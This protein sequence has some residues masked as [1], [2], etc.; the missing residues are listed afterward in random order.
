MNFTVQPVDDSNSHDLVRYC[1]EHGSEHDDSY[2]PGPDFIPSPDQ[3]SYLLFADRSVVGAVSLLRSKRFLDA[4]RGR[5]AIFHS[6]LASAAAYK[7]L[8][9]AI[10]PHFAGLDDVY[11]FLPR[12]KYQT[13]AI[14]S[15][16]GFAVERYSF[17]LLNRS[18]QAEDVE[19][20][21]GFAVQELDPTDKPAV[22]A[23]ADSVNENFA[24]LAGHL[25]L[26]PDVVRSWFTD[27]T[28]LKG[29]LLA[30]LENGRI[31]GTIC[32]TREYEDPNLAEISAFG[33]SKGLR[34]RG[35]GRMLLR[36]GVSFALEKGFPS[37]ILSVN[38]ENDSALSLYRSEGFELTETVV[39]YSLTC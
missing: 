14:L 34:G 25:D 9:S 30:L 16:L 26:P 39:C 10:R 7:S 13:T 5:F 19:F 15:E 1:A 8:L 12:E 29:G 24:E 35:L 11:M 2:L 31:V 33:I 36:S 32:V 6:T 22:R 27:A 21:T 23:Y 37:V 28:Y 17:V 38:A 18:P 20:P 3:P 4:G